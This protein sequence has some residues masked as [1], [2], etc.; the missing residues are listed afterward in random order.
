MMHPFNM[1]FEESDPGQIAIGWELPGNYVKMNYLT[2]VTDQNP[3]KGKYC[4]S[5]SNETSYKPG[6]YGAVIQ[7]IDASQYRG[8]KVYFLAA[9]K[10][11]I[12]PNKGSA[13]LLIR[14]LKS[15]QE[16]G[17]IYTM[18]DNP[19]TINE[20]KIYRIE[21]E[22]DKD[23]E[24]VSYG[25]MLRGT[26]FAYIDAAEFGVVNQYESLNESP[27]P[28][29]DLS[30]KYL[31]A[32]AEIY[33]CSRYFNPSSEVQNID[34]NKFLLAAV[35]NVERAE[36]TDSL[37][38][39]LTGLFT[40][41]V[42]GIGIYPA[43]DEK[44]KEN[45]RKSYDKKIESYSDIILKNVDL[46]WKHI[47]PKT[48]AQSSLINSKIIN[49]NLPQRESEGVVMQL[50][51]A[52]P[53]LGTR[54]KFSIAAKAIVNKG[55]GEG[56]IWMRIDLKDNVI[57]KTLTTA[58]NPITDSTWTYYSVEADIPRDAMF[59]RFALALI[60]EG[61]LWFDDSKITVS[62]DTTGIY[63]YQPKNAGFEDGMTG[64]IVHGWRF[65][66]NSE[67]AG[68]DA[69]VTKDNPFKD[70][71]S[72]IISSNELTKLHLPKPGE[73]YSEDLQAGVGFSLPLTLKVDSNNTLPLPQ[74]NQ[75]KFNSG[76]PDEF[77][78]SGN[79]RTSRLVISIIAWNILKQFNLYIPD[80]K[81]WDN[82]LP[83][84]LKKAAT[85]KNDKEFLS[86]LQ[87]LVSYLKDGQSR[88]WEADDSQ[89]FG[90][91]FLLHWVDGK[92]MV[93]MLSNNNLGL[94]K[95]DE[96]IAINDIPIQKV[97]EKQEE[98]ISSCCDNWKIIRS[99]AELRAGDEN[100][101]LKI[102]YRSP[103]GKMFEK[104][105]TR[106]LSL[107]ELAEKR[108]A[109]FEQPVPG[110]FYCDITRI[111]DEHLKKNIDKL[112]SANGIIFDLRG[113]SNVSEHFLGFFTKNTIPT[114]EWDVPIFTKPNHELIS[115]NII[116]G[117]INPKTPAIT[118]PLVFLTDERTIGLSEE[119]LTL[120]HQNGLGKAI[121]SSTAGSGGEVFAFNIPGNYFI[122]MTSIYAVDQ[123]GNYLY[124]NPIKPDI[125][126]PMSFESVIQEK[127]TAL[128]AAIEY[129]TKK[130]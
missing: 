90:L 40:P 127:D 16:L 22:I 72:L 58:D 26:G 37:I 64:R 17:F 113:T 41:V 27:Y 76:K 111:N 66:P 24:V 60:G 109:E 15:N 31:S 57:Y 74:E 1:D 21:G 48:D 11:N 32:L 123:N 33:G 73:F 53:Y 9:V 29:S 88:A 50:L 67:T 7:T 117:L 69:I 47:G 28:L 99:I 5:L 129:L 52:S 122:S 75:R 97:L 20:W 71:K 116:N 8:K 103:T 130:K 3:Y 10:A 112:S 59:I 18:E 38:S 128:E 101:K 92:L 42:P 93:T 120:V 119:I 77:N 110:I 102:S 78:L 95:G 13:H 63:E 89:K 105:F 126:A 86:T 82:I 14:V 54:L 36:N 46:A 55:E 19:I 39:V 68:Y 45:Y 104:E 43:G 79:D 35:P 30:I 49:V 84:I 124:G 91:P 114:L 83:I 2:S 125:Y 25:L 81:V 115:K 65:L 94:N 121:G 56:Q 118:C 106:S 108:P 12:E 87:F 23:A 51:D 44:A 34:W 80:P 6:M 98:T 61:K 85:D 70:K 100:S 96:I 107:S 4:L 62:G